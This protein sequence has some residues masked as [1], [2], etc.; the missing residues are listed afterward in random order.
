MISVRT[1]V[2]S[3]LRVYR[4][5]ATTVRDFRAQL[6]GGK[7]IWLW[8]SYLLMLMAL[9]MLGYVGLANNTA[10]SVSAVQ[11]MLHSFYI[12]SMQV[13]A[14]A[15]CLIAPSLTAGAIVSEKQRRSLDLLFSAPVSL[16]GYLVG[17]ALSSY[18]YIWMLLVLSIP[19]TSVAVVMGGATWSDVLQ[20]YA[21]LSFVGLVLTSIGLLVSSLCDSVGP[22]V[23]WTYIA[24]AGY[25]SMMTVVGAGTGSPPG[26]SLISN[27]SPVFISQGASAYS[28]IGGM[29]VPN[30]ILAGIISLLLSRVFI[31]GAAS[32][33]S[34]F[35]SKETAGFRFQSLLYVF[36]VT[37]TI[38]WAVN[39]NVTPPSTFAQLMLVELCFTIIFIPHIV[40]YSRDEERKY[41]YDGPTRFS[42]ISTGA[43]SEGLPY[44]GALL[45][46][47]LLGNAVGFFI[48]QTRPYFDPTIIQV[49]P[50]TS[51]A[52]VVVLLN[53]A[54]WGAGFYF[55]LWAIGR[56]FS[57]K[58]KSLKLAR[59]AMI[60][61]TI[62]LFGLPIPI[63]S[64]LTIKEYIQDP[65]S[66][67]QWMAS[68]FY[69]FIANLSA[70]PIY[71]GAM[72]LIGFAAYGLERGMRSTL[73]PAET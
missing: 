71:G 25:L 67:P 45:A 33:L 23:I 24:T 68:L 48:P 4:D 21:L 73:K 31:L 18:R 9:S 58:S 27:L 12:G 65:Y 29:H 72:V 34:Q 15:I 56:G 32:A 30:W 20:T 40:C 1:W 38:C 17:K 55:L 64:L 53:V 47:I 28:I 46:A 52:F 14:G 54:S 62:L 66:L 36:V 19:L 13:L 26:N 8:T 44:L 35:R 69:P 63:I 7:A 3:N 10:L 16:K 61:M 60:G 70:A 39:G 6:R 49:L 2:D 41:R 43:R 5:N 11:L 37:M 22:A 59:S 50:T 57:A 51:Q 42:G